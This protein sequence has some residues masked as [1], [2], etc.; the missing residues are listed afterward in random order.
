MR[1]GMLGE[2]K[3]ISEDI[4]FRQVGYECTEKPNHVKTEARDGLTVACVAWRCIVAKTNDL[5]SV[6]ILKQNKPRGGRLK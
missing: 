6:Y 2:R 4:E 3:I 1:E 5:N